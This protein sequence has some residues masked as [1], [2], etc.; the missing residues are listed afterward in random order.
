MK[1][2]VIG[3][4]NHQFD[5]IFF[6]RLSTFLKADNFE[7]IVNN[8]LFDRK[9]KIYIENKY[10]NIKFLFYDFGEERRNSILRY[11]YLFKVNCQLNKVVQKN[12][13]LISLDKSKLTSRILLRKSN[14]AIIVQ[15]QENHNSFSLDFKWT[16]KE[17]VKSFFLGL[18]ITKVFSNST[19][20][21]R[22]YVVNLKSTEV[23]YPE[24][25]L[26]PPLTC[27]SKSNIVVIFGSRFF[28]WNFI[29]F[30][31]FIKNLRKF[32]L[33]IQI[34]HPQSELVYIPHPRESSREYE[35]IVRELKINMVKIHNYLC[36]EH[37]LIENP[38][39]NTCYSIS[40]TAS[41]SA[42]ELGFNS[43][44]YYK[45]FGFPREIVDSFD[46]IFQNIPNSI[47]VKN[48]H[49]HE[50]SLNREYDPIL[51]NK[52]NQYDKKYSK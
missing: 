30:E 48:W 20:Y 10:T 11:I 31:K 1:N 25:S 49:F 16:L 33:S 32:Y 15:Q 24:F 26:L 8:R 44:V 21:V 17:S 18:G 37:F 40:S 38:N 14:Q 7:L 9:Q 41:K 29:E 2:N 46:E 39:V 45:I 27:I 52:L 19:G 4:V 13:I 6:I 42:Y 28:S 50:F 22:K 35:F 12:K 5:L 36:A 34:M 3:V 51:I 43:F 23:I 47:V